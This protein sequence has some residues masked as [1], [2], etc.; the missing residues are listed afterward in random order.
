MTRSLLLLA[1]LLA[2]QA[3]AGGCA[4]Y[5]EPPSSPDPPPFELRLGP[6]DRVRVSVWSEEKL[7]HD[8]EVHPDGSINFPLIGDVP[9]VGLTLD[10]ARI[11]LA[12]R[13]KAVVLDP[14]VSVSLLESRSSLVH[15]LG[16]VV[17]PGVVS[18]VRGATTL[19]AV[20]AAGGYLAPTADL[21][22][23]RVVR[24]R[25]GERVAYEVDLEDVL[26]GEASDMWLVPGDV[27]YVP[28]RLLTRWDRWWRPAGPLGDPV[29]AP[30][31]R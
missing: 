22:G 15:V 5:Q 20:Q 24:D 27:V 3:T 4:S 23:V 26:S 9:V 21:G 25:M 29:D 31:P 6:G 17:R 10:E 30:Q 2:L 16:E 7:Q 13:I 14:T 18:Y 8:L 11:D 28:P 1:L 12:Q 19:G